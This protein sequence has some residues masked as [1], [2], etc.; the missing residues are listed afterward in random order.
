M[1][2]SLIT[3]KLI[4]GRGVSMGAEKSFTFLVEGGRATA[5]PPILY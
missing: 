1:V 5:G 2:K 4:K 3:S